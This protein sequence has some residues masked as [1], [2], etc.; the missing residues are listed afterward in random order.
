MLIIVHY[1]IHLNINRIDTKCVD[2]IA[3]LEALFELSTSNKLV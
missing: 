3:T 2:E 1:V